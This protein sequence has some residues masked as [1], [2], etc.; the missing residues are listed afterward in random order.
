MG[1]ST[2]RVCTCKC[3]SQQCPD[4]AASNCAGVG[5]GSA[6]RAAV[7]GAGSRQV[8]RRPCE[9]T[10]P[11]TQAAERYPQ[12]SSSPETSPSLCCMHH[13]FALSLTTSSCNRT[14]QMG[15]CCEPSRLAARRIA[16]VVDG[17]SVGEPHL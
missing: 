7:G 12:N 4:D 1:H 8:C 17:G 10:Q 15:E 5:F 9:Q 11:C 2:E 6:A 16:Q 13:K 3:D 14:M